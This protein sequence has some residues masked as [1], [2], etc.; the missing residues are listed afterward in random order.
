MSRRENRLDERGVSS[1]SLPI[2]LR[3]LLELEDDSDSDGRESL[4]FE[5]WGFMGFL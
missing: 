4:E 1:V 2:V 5:T 3:L